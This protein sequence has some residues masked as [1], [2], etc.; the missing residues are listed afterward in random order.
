MF[1]NKK[2]QM[3]LYELEMYNKNKEQ[4]RNFIPAINETGE[5]GLYDKIE[6]KFY[7][8]AGTDEFIYEESISDLDSTKVVTLGKKYGQLPV[9]VKEGYEF[10]GWYT[11]SD[12][13]EIIT[14]NTI[15]TSD[16]EN[17]ILYAKCEK[18]KTTNENCLKA[19]KTSLFFK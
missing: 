10:K 6:N 14:S 8:N 2:A 5:I 16:A 4:I 9:P 18:I 3:K 12:G 1:Y 19:R 17:Q 13:G 11:K 7:N 15:V